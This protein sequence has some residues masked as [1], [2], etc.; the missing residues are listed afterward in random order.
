MLLVQTNQP[1]LHDFLAH[2]QGLQ[3][4]LTFVPNI[5]TSILISLSIL[6]IF[7]SAL[8]HDN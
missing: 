4:L 8:L 7:L 2:T 1:T 6:L 5:L 3:S